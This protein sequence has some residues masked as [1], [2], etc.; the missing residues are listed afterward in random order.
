MWLGVTHQKMS[1]AEI[2]ALTRQKK[3]AYIGMPV[4]YPGISLIKQGWVPLAAPSTVI[5]SY[6][7]KVKV[8]LYLGLKKV[9]FDVVH[10]ICNFLL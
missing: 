10:K 3:F 2:M 4:L 1:A 6:V 9:P 8:L 7:D 5:S